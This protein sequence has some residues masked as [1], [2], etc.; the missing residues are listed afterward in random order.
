MDTVDKRTRSRMMAAIPSKDTMPEVELR[1]HLFRLGYRYRLHQRALP[2]RPDL[3]FGK[4]RVVVFVNGCFWHQHGC[5]AVAVPSTRRAWWRKK[6]D[7]NR[8]RDMAALKALRETGWRTVVVWECSFGRSVLRYS[9]A[10]D[11]VAGRVA[12]FLT[13]KRK[14]LEI[15]GD[16]RG[17][18]RT[19]GLVTQL[20]TFQKVPHGE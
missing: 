2:G 15:T 12:T 17:Q 13:S 19:R 14:E 18:P 4:H 5:R 3:V 9:D 16:R 7:G 6:L 11:R 8:K 1:R 10:A 20:R